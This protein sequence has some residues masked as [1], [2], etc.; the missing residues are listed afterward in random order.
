MHF[1]H[2]NQILNVCKLKQW[3]NSIAVYAVAGNNFLPSRD[4][5]E[6]LMD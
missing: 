1:P 5:T 6:I 2:G 4:C 3:Q